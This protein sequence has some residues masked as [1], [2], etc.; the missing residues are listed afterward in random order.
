MFC[1]NTR[2]TETDAFFISAV[3]AFF[4]LHLQ[5]AKKIRQEAS[6]RYAPF[7]PLAVSLSLAW[8]F[9]QFSLN[10]FAPSVDKSRFFK[11]MSF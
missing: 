9:I 8:N 6:L 2:F 10:L 1:L 11:L 3:T 7:Q 5:N 4:I